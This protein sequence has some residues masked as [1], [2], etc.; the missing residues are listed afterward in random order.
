MSIILIALVSLNACAG[1]SHGIRIYPQKV[2]LFVDA[3]KDSARIL[4]LPDIKNAYEVKP[5]SF[6]SKHDFSVKLAEAQVTELSSNQDSTAALALL[7]KIVE[8]AGELGGE[9]LKAA[10]EG[11]KAGKGAKPVADVDLGS[12]LGLQS[13]IYEFNEKGLVKISS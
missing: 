1:V 9:A 10:I 3:K 7:Q 2:Y 4:T 11:A 12:A 5:W 6:L 13:G 8:I